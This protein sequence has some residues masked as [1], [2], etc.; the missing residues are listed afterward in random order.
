MIPKF[1]T[2]GSRRQLLWQIYKETLTITYKA[3]CRSIINYAALTWSPQLCDT[4]WQSLQATQIAVLRTISG[5]HLMTSQDHLHEATMMPSEKP[6][7]MMISL[8]VYLLQHPW[9]TLGYTER[10]PRDIRKCR[11]NNYL[12]TLC[13]KDKNVKP[14]SNAREKQVIRQKSSR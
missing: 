4:V 10:P 14:P 13:N 2:K 6:H 9:N 3:I 1:C 8:N 12:P 5:C 11:T 7:N